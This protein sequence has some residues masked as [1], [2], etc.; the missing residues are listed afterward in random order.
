MD[1]F[2]LFEKF[3]KGIFIVLLFIQFKVILL[4]YYENN[5]QVSNLSQNASIIDITDYYNLYLLITTEKKIYT[6]MPPQE[7]SETTSNIINITS[8][9]TYD[10]N[11]VILVCTGDYLLS[12]ININTGEEIPLINYSEFSLSI[13]N[14]NYTCCISIFNNIVYIGIPQI[15]ANGLKNHMFKIA[16]MDS[17][18]NNGPI[19]DK[20][21]EKYALGY[22]LPNL[23]KISYP[24]QLSCEVILCNNDL[25]D[26]RLVIGYLKYENSKYTY[27]SNVVKKDFSGFPKCVEIATYSKLLSLRLQK[28]NSTFI[29]YLITNESYEIYFDNTDNYR[30]KI[31]GR[32]K[33]N[34]FLDTFNSSGDS[35][36]YHNQYIFYANRIEET[37]FNL[38]IKSNFS[39]STIRFQEKN[40]IIHKCIGYYD[41][42][43]DKLEMIY[44]Y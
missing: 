12:K 10:T 42:T 28:I 29:R 16:L 2:I 34:P 20:L 41:E 25:E 4:D 24:R 9:V 32:N 3:N 40:K 22:N 33:I 17:D 27:Y 8:A 39:N 30:I 13:H 37:N 5:Y 31:V 1:C 44:Q 6:G 35:F 7:I 19:F 11:Y 18:D 26:P 15:T 43:N 21:I 38:F 23:G 36:F 14:L